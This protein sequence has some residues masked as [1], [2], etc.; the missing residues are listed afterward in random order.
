MVIMERKGNV[1]VALSIVQQLISLNHP[2]GYYSVYQHHEESYWQH[3]PNWI[4]EAGQTSRIDTILDIGLAYGTLGLFSKL[5]TGADLYGLDLVKLISDD[6]LK[7]YAINYMTKNIETEEVA[8]DTRFDLI[9]FTEVLE[10]FNYYCIPTL[11]KIK[12]M[13]NDGGIIMFSTPAQ[14]YWGKVSSYDSWRH[15]PTTD[16]P[17]ELKDA[18]MYQYSLDELTDIFK[19][20]GIKIDRMQ[21]A[22]GMNSFKHFNMQLS[23]EMV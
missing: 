22:D 16:Q 2:S 8:Y 3:I 10:H 1:M 17:V 7:R 21:L 23:K 13:L 4:L 18:H 12:A 6:L 14:E 20:I 11:L 9:I 19:I 15:M 5:N